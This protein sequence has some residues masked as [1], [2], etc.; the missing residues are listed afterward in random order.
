MYCFHIIYYYMIFLCNRSVGRFTMRTGRPDTARSLISQRRPGQ[1]WLQRGERCCM[2]KGQHSLTARLCPTYSQRSFRGSVHAR[3]SSWHEF[4]QN[5]MLEINE[6]TWNIIKQ[7]ADIC[8]LWFLKFEVLSR[9]SGG[10]LD[11]CPTKEDH[12]MLA[13]NLVVRSCHE[14]SNFV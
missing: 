3:N 1:N 6:N 2:V 7:S 10:R 14:I 4:D 11:P 9:G 5:K 8:R 13:G 12:Q